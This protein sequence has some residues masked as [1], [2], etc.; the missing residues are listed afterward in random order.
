VAWLKPIMANETAPLPLAG[1]ERNQRRITQ[2]EAIA[3]SAFGLVHYAFRHNPTKQGR[4]RSL[5]FVARFFESFTH[6]VNNRVAKV[7]VCLSNEGSDHCR[8]SSFAT[9]LLVDGGKIASHAT[10]LSMFRCVKLGPTS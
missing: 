6:C 9:L 5:N 1:I 8:C 3:V 4:L 7:S 10:D 2:P